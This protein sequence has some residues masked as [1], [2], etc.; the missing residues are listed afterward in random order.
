MLNFYRNNMNNGNI[1]SALAVVVCCVGNVLVLR[2]NLEK[3]LREYT[4]F[5]KDYFSCN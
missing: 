4:Y 5:I 1:S 2:P 3:L